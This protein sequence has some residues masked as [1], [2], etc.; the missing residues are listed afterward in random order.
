VKSLFNPAPPTPPPC[1]PD[2]PQPNTNEKWP[3]PKEVNDAWSAARKT[4]WAEVEKNIALYLSGAGKGEVHSMSCLDAAKFAGY[5]KPSQEEEDSIWASFK[6]AVEPRIPEMKQQARAGSSQAYNDLMYCWRTQTI[7]M[8]NDE[9]H[10]IKEDCH[11]AQLAK[12]VSL[13][14]TTC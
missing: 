5:W 1:Y 4:W 8:T 11:K 13:S 7:K 3:Y 6:S 14:K 9:Y 12:G 10:S 2:Y